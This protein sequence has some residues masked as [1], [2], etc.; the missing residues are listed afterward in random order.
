MSFTTAEL[1][2]LKL[3]DRVDGQRALPTQKRRGGNPRIGITPAQM[4]HVEQRRA[5]GATIAQVAAELG[6]NWRRLQR[7][8]R[9][10]KLDQ[11]EAT[12]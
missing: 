6:I 1:A 3:S 7:E 10:I 11:G 2:L 12:T 5:A 8:L 4:V 9:R